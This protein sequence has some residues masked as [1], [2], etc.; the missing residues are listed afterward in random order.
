MTIGA[1]DKNNTTYTTKLNG[2]VK[3]DVVLMGAGAKAVPNVNLGKWDDEFFI[4]L[5]Y[6][7][8]IVTNE[9]ESLQG[10]PFSWGPGHDLVRS[11]G[12]KTSGR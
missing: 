5:N 4:N 9:I 8:M 2:P 7:D 1:L 6:A 11:G 10:T 12:R 3:A